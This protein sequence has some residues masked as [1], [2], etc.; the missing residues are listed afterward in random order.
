MECVRNKGDHNNS[1]SFLSIICFRVGEESRC[2][3]RILARHT[4]Q[5]N[6][7]FPSRTWSHLSSCSAA[8]DINLLLWLEGALTARS[9]FASLRWSDP[10][11]RSR[12][13]CLTTRDYYFAGMITPPA[14]KQQ[15]WRYYYYAPTNTNC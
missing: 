11:S 7:R 3:L 6:G 14:G 9:H 13:L 5:L 4:R 8:A 15:K 12:C 2:L 1:K 10:V